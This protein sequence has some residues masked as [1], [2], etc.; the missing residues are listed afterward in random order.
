MKRNESLARVL[1]LIVVFILPLFYLVAQALWN[2]RIE[3]LMPRVGANWAFAPD[4][5]VRNMRGGPVSDDIEFSLEFDLSIAPKRLE[6]EFLAFSEALLE[7]NGVDIALT[8][9]GDWKEAI[10]I[11]LAPHLRRGRNELVVRVH[12][13]GSIPAL[14][15]TTPETLRTPGA[16]RAA[17]TS[18]PLHT[19]P[20]VPPTAEV[21]DDFE[22]RR[23]EP[24]A[25]VGW[26]GKGGAAAL[27]FAWMAL[28]IGAVSWAVIGRPASDPSEG[29][30]PATGT[31]SKS[32]ASTV[33]LV[34]AFGC[35]LWNAVHYP[36]Q[37]T[38]FDGDNH[39]DYVE[40]VADDWRVPDPR[41]GFQMYQPPGYYFLA[42]AA[43]TGAGGSENREAA[44]K[45]V[46]FVGATA[47]F[48]IVFL[49]WWFSRRLFEDE[50]SRAVATAFSAFLP[51]L[52][53]CSPMISNETFA[54]F[55]IA[56]AFCFVATERDLGSPRIAL[57]AGLLCALALLSKYTALFT[58][59]G[60]GLF[61]ASRSLFAGASRPAWRPL[62][63][64]L[65]PVV[66]LSGWLY[67][68]NLTQFGDPFVGNWDAATGFAYEQDPG[69]R[70]PS[71]YFAF[72]RLFLQPIEHA[73]WLSW[74]DGIYA[75]MW[76]DPFQSFLNPGDVRLPIWS[77]IALLL[78]L[79]PTILIALGFV[80]STRRAFARPFHGVDFLLVS[81]S[82]WSLTALLS[83]SLEVPFYSTVKAFFVL[84]L[85]PIFGVQLARG[86]NFVGA[87]SPSLR[88]TGDCVLVC[89]ALVNIGLYRYPV[90]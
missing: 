29:A 16:W 46:Q 74:P 25:L 68:R 50:A 18:D 22:F 11:D 57:S 79:W 17:S 43:Y 71:Y 84:S 64:F 56:L 14:L 31:S 72:G 60:A 61:F 20:A 24:G 4:Q 44:L 39:I 33:V 23:H 42:A 65:V 45:A 34:V 48:G 41:D 86:R 66:V 78:A 54:G 13:P 26:A 76:S 88:F 53:Y 82:V 87:G 75:S 35:H 9:P 70:T 85:V 83:F 36:Y 63:A 90:Q 62:L 3:F 28:L 10:R 5:H 49:T 89:L 30:R 52:L 38:Y 59:A 67:V 58:V 51:M 6:V 55:A 8:A 80:E 7:V 2:P 47:G 21:P 77:A 15:V 32:I 40:A 19:R 27:V 69:Y 37:R 81:V 73:P 1:F 12:N